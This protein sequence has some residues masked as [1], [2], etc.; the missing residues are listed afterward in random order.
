MFQRSEIRKGMID[1][2]PIMVSVFPFGL[3][4]GV[5][6]VKS[7][8]TAVEALLSSIIVLAGAS[9]FISLPLFAAGASPAIEIFLNFR[10]Y[11][12]PPFAARTRSSM[13]VIHFSRKRIGT[14]ISPASTFPFLRAA[15]KSVFRTASIAA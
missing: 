6:A 11:L 15:L 13:R 7:S 4:Y 3:V 8:L 10:K 12:H 1:A 9:Q 2:L 14:L 5:L